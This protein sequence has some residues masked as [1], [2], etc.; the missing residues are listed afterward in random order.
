MT[1]DST[2]HEPAPRRTPMGIP[3]R[4]HTKVTAGP[5]SPKETP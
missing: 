5:G 2:L 3:P 4:L 1:T